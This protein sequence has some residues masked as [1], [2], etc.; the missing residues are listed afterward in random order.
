M[1]VSHH[2]FNLK[3]IAFFKLMNFLNW[4]ID[5]IFLLLQKN[6]WPS[7]IKNLKAL[8]FTWKSNSK[9]NIDPFPPFIQS[10]PNWTNQIH[11]ATYF[12]HVTFLVKSLATLLKWANKRTIATG[13]KY[14]TL[15][16]KIKQQIVYANLWIIMCVLSVDAR[17]N[18]LPHSRHWKR[19]RDWTMN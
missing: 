6:Y 16:A 18:C 13:S 3:L 17:L 12:L 14:L 7:C 4:W 5:S 11:T 10:T 1:G 9:N 8:S 19:Q 2:L 15:I